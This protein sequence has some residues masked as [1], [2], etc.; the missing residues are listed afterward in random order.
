MTHARLRG[1]PVDVARETK[2]VILPKRWNDG[3]A[4]VNAEIK[5][6]IEDHRFERHATL[7][8]RVAA[9][10]AKIN[11]LREQRAGRLNDRRQPAFRTHT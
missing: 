9:L 6:I 3:P 4:A 11:E 1:D 5:A 2:R 8:S 7:M 10:E